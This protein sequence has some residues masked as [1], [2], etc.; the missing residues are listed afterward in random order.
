MLC[1]GSKKECSFFRGRVLGLILDHLMMMLAPRSDR[2]IGKL[3]LV[4]TRVVM[5]ACFLTF[6]VLVVTGKTVIRGH[7]LYFRR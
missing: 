2:M 4:I 3:V 7:G 5:T 1:L 6:R